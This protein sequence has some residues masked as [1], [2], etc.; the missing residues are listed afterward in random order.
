MSTLNQKP[1]CYCCSLDLTYKVDKTCE[2]TVCVCVCV[3]VVFTTQLNTDNNVDDDDMTVTGVFR[4]TH[5]IASS[6]LTAV[7]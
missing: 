4:R 6:R 7:A 3:C 5:V 1:Y 2:L